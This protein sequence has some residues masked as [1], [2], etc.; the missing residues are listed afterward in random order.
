MFVVGCDKLYSCMYY[1]A[2]LIVH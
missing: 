2:Y 1:G